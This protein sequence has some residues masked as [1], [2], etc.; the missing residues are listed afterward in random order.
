VELKIAYGTRWS[1]VKRIVF[2]NIVHIGL[3]GKYEAANITTIIEFLNVFK[4]IY[5]E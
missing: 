4:T 5:E 1:I 2:F 3:S